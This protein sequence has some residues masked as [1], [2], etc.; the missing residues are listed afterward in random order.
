MII[1]ER[2]T[3]SCL[4]LLEEVGLGDY[5]YQRACTLS[6]LDLTGYVLFGSLFLAIAILG[7]LEVRMFI[8]E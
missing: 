4:K 8:D 7:T 1:Y 6:I 5:M 2:K 3:E